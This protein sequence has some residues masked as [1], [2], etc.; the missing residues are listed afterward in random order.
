[1]NGA[2]LFSPHLDD[3]TFSAS[4]RLSAGDIDVVTLF[5]G[6]PPTETGLRYFDR[7]TGATSS[8]ARIL[9]RWAEDDQ[10]MKILNC[11]TSRL[12]ELDRDYRDGPVDTSRL[13]RL[14][15]PFT[16][17]ATE[18]WVPAGILG[19]PDHIATREAVRATVP[20]E[21]DLYFYA[22][23]PYSIRFGW[24]S[25]VNGQE[26]PPY[27]NVSFWL[28]HELESCGLN[29]KK[30]HPMVFKLDNDLQR[31][32]EQAALC[33]RTQLPVLKLNPEDAPR[34]QEFLTYELAWKADKA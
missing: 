15:E 20:A 6:A 32:K 31:Q 5:S 19:H 11:E 23:I 12:G 8:H 22:D 2:V 21:A 7:L 16:R 10:A 30:L 33:Y 14:V 25:W 3:A 13:E 24:P 1:M 27:I 4:R 28:E 26:E 29:R 9:E 18:V 17:N 34:W